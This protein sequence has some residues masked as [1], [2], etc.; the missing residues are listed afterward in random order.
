MV[1]GFDEVETPTLEG[2]GSS[3]RQVRLRQ[4]LLDLIQFRFRARLTPPSHL[5]FCH[6]MSS[7]PLHNPSLAAEK[8]LRPRVGAAAKGRL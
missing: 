2:S 7:I 5:G 1:F 6:V 4:K 3:P 8:G